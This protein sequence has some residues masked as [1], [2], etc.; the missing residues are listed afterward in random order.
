MFDIRYQYALHTT[1]LEEQPLSDRTLSRFRARV[2][3]YE[4]KHDV[5]FLAKIMN[6]REIEIPQEQ[7]HM[8]PRI[9]F[10]CVTVLETSTIQAS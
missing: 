6:Q 3:A 2:P 8:K 4:T 10:I 5:D 7:H 1:S 9:L